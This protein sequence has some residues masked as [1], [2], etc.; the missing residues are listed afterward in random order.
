MKA[1]FLTKVDPERHGRAL[2]A[3]RSALHELG[4]GPATHSAATQIY[5]RV[6]DGESAMLGLLANTTAEKTDVLTAMLTSAGCEASV[7]NYELDE[8]DD[9]EE[10][11]Y[12]TSRDVAILILGHCGGQPVPACAVLAGLYRITQESAYAD[13][14]EVIANIFPWMQKEI[15][16]VIQGAE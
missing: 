10:F 3:I 12:S 14:I 7:G 8:E 9:E 4:N 15:A 1:L 13:A 6:K 16:A 5:D 11:E 2:L